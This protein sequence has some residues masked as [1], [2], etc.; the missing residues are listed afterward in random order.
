[1]KGLLQLRSQK[2]KTKN[3]PCIEF[4]QEN[5]IKSQIQSVYYI[6]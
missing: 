5:L 4:I 1:M 3:K 6:Y 2:I